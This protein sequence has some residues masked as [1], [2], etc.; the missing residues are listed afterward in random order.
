MQQLDIDS[1]HP[2]PTQSNA[3]L[4]VA[5]QSTVTDN[6]VSCCSLPPPSLPSSSSVPSLSSLQEASRRQQPP[7]EDRE[8]MLRVVFCT[9][10]GQAKTFFDR[11]E[12]RGFVLFRRGF[13]CA[14]FFVRTTLS[15]SPRLHRRM[16]GQMNVSMAVSITTFA[17][18]SLPCF[19]L[20]CSQSNTIHTHQPTDRTTERPTYLPSTTATLTFTMTMFQHRRN[21]NRATFLQKAPLIA[22]PML[23]VAALFCMSQYRPGSPHVRR[24]LGVQASATTTSSLFADDSSSFQNHHQEQMPEIISQH[25]PRCTEN[26]IAYF[27]QKDHH[28]KKH[29]PYGDLVRSLDFLYDNYLNV[30]DYDDDNNNNN[31]EDKDSSN[32]NSNNEK[33]NNAD[34]DESVNIFLFH[35]GDFDESDLQHLEWRYDSVIDTAGSPSRSFHIQLVNLAGTKYWQLPTE[36]LHDDQSDWHGSQDLNSRHLRR[37]NAI[38]IWEF[39]HQLNRQQ[40]CSY[41]QI[42]R[43]DSNSF[44]YSPIRYNLF[45]Y[46]KLQQYR[47]GY[48]LCSYDHVNT[49][50]HPYETPSQQVWKEFRQ[51]HANAANEAHAL[52]DG[53]DDEYEA[54]CTFA[55]GFY[56]ADLQFFLSRPVQSFLRFV[57]R[58]G[59]LYRHRLDDSAV[60]TM[61]A[62]AFVG[63]SGIHRF[64][65]F[66]YEHF[67][68]YPS[69]GCPMEGALQ[70]GYNDENAE[71]TMSEWTY[72]FVQKRNCAVGNSAG[73]TRIQTRT[74]M[75]LSPQNDHLIKEWKQD[76]SLL[77]VSA[78]DTE[79][80]KRKRRHHPTASS[81]NRKEDDSLT[82]RRP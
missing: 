67:V 51:S 14:G 34:K 45:D 70:A 81:S 44:V 47:F 50:A 29:G 5:N 79:R 36:L 10:G 62:R 28:N 59:Y 41:Q 38:G 49:V 1:I 64:L 78:G 22:A 57:D 39:F 56:V 53:I 11:A 33:T 32:S 74:A 52:Q 63:N 21:A 15:F 3:N 69:D 71:T 76:L 7:P 20:P 19:F 40:G 18:V 43:M 30:N 12:R 72:V 46:M 66:T 8:Q 16:N 25:Q 65:D 61:A 31:K 6:C 42:L 24:G 2:D 23:L 82:M 55:G 77:T 35:T 4:L 58:S 73:A 80:R 26:A 27:V 48:R 68:K 13:S 37:W 75:D 54:A 17:T 60:L 9:T